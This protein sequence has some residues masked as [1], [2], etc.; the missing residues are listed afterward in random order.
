MS[1]WLAPEAVVIFDPSLSRMRTARAGLVIGVESRLPVVYSG[2]CQCMTNNFVGVS[3]NAGSMGRSAGGRS[4]R[5]V[6]HARQLL[7]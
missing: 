2:T 4:F 7:Q 1:S 5:G 3:F 6:H